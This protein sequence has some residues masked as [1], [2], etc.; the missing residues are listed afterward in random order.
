MAQP[1]AVRH[2][3]QP[4][5]QGGGGERCIKLPSFANFFGEPSLEVR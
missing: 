4:L 2:V 1:I 3:D 5:Q